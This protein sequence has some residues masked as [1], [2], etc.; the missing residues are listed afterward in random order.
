MPGVKRY[1]NE[2]DHVRHKAF[3][4]ARAQANHRQEPWLMTIE[5]WFE[6]WRD[7]QT[8]SQ[9]GRSPNSVCMTRLDSSG[10]WS[11]ANTIIVTRSGHLAEKNMKEYDIL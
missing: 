4:K 11:L 6:L 8:W 2:F 5:D 7:P 1:S 9:R 10:P 3:S